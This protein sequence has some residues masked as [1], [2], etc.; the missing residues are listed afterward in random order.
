MPRRIYPAEGH[1]ET[2]ES[3]SLFTVGTSPA[4]KDLIGKLSYVRGLKREIPESNHIPKRKRRLCESNCPH[5]MIG[6][7]HS[8]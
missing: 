4:A 2:Y 8:D 3:M 6:F 5:N 1:K 7:D